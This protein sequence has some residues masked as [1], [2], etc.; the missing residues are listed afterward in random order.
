MML[1]D[2][3]LVEWARPL[4]K[5]KKYSQ[6]VD[7]IIR[8]SYEEDHFRWLVQVTTQCLK[9][10]PKERL[11]M[12]VVVSS[13]QGIAESELCHMTE[14]ITPAISDSRIV[15]DIY[16]SQGLT[17]AKAG[18]P[19]LEKEQIE[20]RFYGEENKLRLI[21]ENTHFYMISQRDSDKLSQ[22]EEQMQRRPQGEERISGK[23][24]INDH[25]KDQM[26]VGQ[27]N[28][29]EEQ[30]SNTL[31]REDIT[32]Q[33]ISINHMIDHTNGDK[34]KKNLEEGSNFAEMKIGLIQAPTSGMI[35]QTKADQPV[36]DKTQMQR[37]FH[38][39]LLDGHQDETILE[40][41]KFSACSICKRRRL[42]IAWPKNFT[43][44][45]LLVATEGF[46]TENSLSESE[47][48][49][50]FKG[51]LERREKIVVKKYQITTSHEEVL[52]SEV[53]LLNS[54]R[55]KNMV[56][57]LGSC[58]ENSQLLIVYEQ[59]CNGSLDQYLTRGSFQSLTW[60]QR[61][62]VA[63]G[64]ARG[65]K[66]LHENNIMHGNIK[67]SNIL[68]THDF[69][70]LIG[71]FS[72]REGRLDQK[73]SR[74]D[75]SAS[76]SG[77]TAPEY[78]ENGKLSNKTDVY[79]FGVV[80]LEL[81]TGRRAMDKLPGGK[82]LVGWARPLLGGK[83]YPQLVDPK[84]IN[85]YEEEKLLWLVQVTEQC[86]RKNPKERFTMNMVVS[87]LQGIAESD[88][89]C[90][91]E[92]SSP[93]KSCLTHDD[94]ATVRI[95]GQMKA[96]PVKQEQEWID[97][98]QYE[99]ERNLRLPVKTNHMIDQR[100]ADQLIQGGENVQS[101]PHEEMSTVAV[102]INDKIDQINSDLQIKE[103]QHIK[104]SFHIEEMDKKV[105]KEQKVSKDKKQVQGSCDED[106]L[107]GNEA[108]IILENSKFFICSICKSRRPN[109][110]LQKKYTYEEL[111][112]ATEGFSI[113]YSLSEGEYGPVFRGQLEN[114]QE[115]VIK[116]HAFTSLQ[117]QKAFMSE[118]QVL[119]N[120]RHENVIMLLGSCIR[121]SQLLVVYEKACNGSLDQYLSRGSGRSLTWGERVKVAIGVARGLKYLHENNII[122]GRIKPSNILLNHDFK[123]LVGDF[124]LGKERCEL[125]S[126]Y[127]HK[128]M[129][130]C[131]YTAP[132][133]HEGGKLST[134]AD[135][136]SF[137]VV[138]VELITGRMITDK[139]HSQK[140]LVE[141]ARNLLGGRKFLQLVDPELS[142]SY[143]EQELLS[144]IH[145]TEHCLK[146][147]PKERLTMNMVV[148]ALPCLVD[149]NKIHVEEHL[150][151]EN[152]SV[153]EEEQEEPLKEDLGTENNSEEKEDNIKCNR[154]YNETKVNQKCDINS[155]NCDCES[156]EKTE[157]KERAS[158]K[159]SWE[160][161]SSYVGAREFYLDGAQ[162]YTVCEEFF[163]WC[164]S[165]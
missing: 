115:I 40:S 149:S 49:P 146:K 132:E 94:P 129:R 66:Y 154:H 158:T 22:T 38:E 39:N 18:Q 4:L 50:T 88:E 7:P 31:Y 111:Q 28:E 147:N 45:E 109:S 118:F 153:S 63:M 1:E 130:N 26:V 3:G 150:S 156:R 138:L 71:D 60:N 62:K 15:P 145:V 104:G 11:S 47:D 29:L 137:G 21:V 25:T 41:S 6:L 133:C 122:H 160:G 2:K 100:N 52:K 148:S 5:G 9:K 59:V 37:S 134:K 61:L 35:E 24:I 164:D 103:K 80:L 114:N 105:E 75:K 57:L 124:A 117:E 113:K 65:L 131:G 107:D 90:V 110:G 81:I 27:P 127:K 32:T 74:K 43:Y 10:N 34:L 93:E 106:L 91:I 98:N 112:V 139:I 30:M 142:S 95:Q 85:S 70:P 161:C 165:I 48:G 64:T 44:D 84:I 163:G 102:T 46:S 136:Y 116:Q 36:Q 72:F 77:Y 54:A 42:N 96:D 73:K 82:G 13:L 120:A 159:I 14:D 8:N 151:P 76:N 23:M 19:S 141:C 58:T 53:Q 123:P 87:A 121:L 140:C 128:N 89:C 12:S 101:S 143:D 126:P 16:G 56:T 144:L 79:S 55:H 108:K 83:K 67:P 51:L 68:L 33:K 17:T 119:I 78:L 69:E 155:T 125:Q 99:D 92:Y 152:S 97:R 157:E 86:L 20:S 135:V 162:E